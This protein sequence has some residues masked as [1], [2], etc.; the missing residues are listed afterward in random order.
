MYPQTRGNLAAVHT[1]E[2][3]DLTYKK[4][5]TTVLRNTITHFCNDVY[6]YGTIHGNISACILLV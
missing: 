1:L 4:N 2:T 6:A 3:A 5:L